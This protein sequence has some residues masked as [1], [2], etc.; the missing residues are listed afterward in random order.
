MHRTA[1]LAGSSKPPFCHNWKPLLQ[2]A[3]A[4]VCVVALVA[5]Q[6]A[7]DAPSQP[8]PAPPRESS[9]VRLP[10]ARYEIVQP[11]LE[12]QDEQGNTLWKLEAQSLRAESKESHAQGILV[13]VRGWLY[14]N[15]KPVLEFTAPYARAH[16]ERREVEAWGKVVAV[17]KTNDARLE[18]G[19]ILWKA[20]QDRILAREGVWLRWGA[21]E[22]RE[23]A[24]NVDTALERVWSGE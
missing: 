22:M 1:H 20:R 3:L 16:S 6:S 21:F 17:S 4:L 19:R 12:Q 11:T 15:G 24:L 7:P 14:R 8:V 13:R 9:G 10:D 18:A 23:H 5:C 2:G